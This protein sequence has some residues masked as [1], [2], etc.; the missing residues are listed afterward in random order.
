MKLN[1]NL[2]PT[3]GTRNLHPKSHLPSLPEDPPKTQRPWLLLFANYIRALFIYLHTYLPTYLRIPDCL[4]A[5]LPTFPMY[6]LIHSD[7]L[8]RIQSHFVCIYI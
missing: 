3:L 4:P 7:Y 8:T 2:M 1:S 6:P 5:C